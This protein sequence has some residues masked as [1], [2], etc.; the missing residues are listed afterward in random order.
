MVSRVFSLHEGLLRAHAA[1]SCQLGVPA[2]G[3]SAVQGQPLDNPPAGQIQRH[4]LHC[5][6]CSLQ[7]SEPFGLPR[8]DMRAICQGM[9]GPLTGLYALLLVEVISGEQQQVS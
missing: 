6:N 4:Q 3:F 2:H 9:S 7:E 8:P 1:V 5:S